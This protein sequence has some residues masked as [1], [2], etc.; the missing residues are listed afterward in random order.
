M[1]AG[2]LFGLSG[3]ASPLTGELYAKADLWGNTNVDFF[4]TLAGNLSLEVRDGTLNRFT[5]LARI[6]SFI[7]LKNWITADFPDPRAAGIPFKTLTGDF[8]GHNGD[9][10]TDNLKLEGPVMDIIARGNVTFGTSTTMDMRIGLIPFNTVNW[11][12]SKIP[13]MG[14]NL[15]SGSSGLVAAYFQVKGPVSN[16]SVSP[17]PI[18]SVTEFVIKT[19]SLPINIIAPN[20]I[21]R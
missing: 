5:L 4:D 8:K 18:T 16:P 20:T 17:K 9:F 21:N 12:V 19:L 1:S 14:G 10:Y 3:K 7:D 6:L 13:L 2:L 15:A 11:I